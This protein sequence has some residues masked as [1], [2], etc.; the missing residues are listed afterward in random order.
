MSNAGW[1]TPSASGFVHGAVIYNHWLWI[2]WLLWLNIMCY[3]IVKKKNRINDILECFEMTC[4]LNEIWKWTDWS[5]LTS[6][7]RTATIMTITWTRCIVY[8]CP[9]IMLIGFFCKHKLFVYSVFHR[10]TCALSVW[11]SFLFLFSSALS[12]FSYFYEGYD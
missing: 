6:E 8:V 11:N 10:I 2:I 3:M 7:V 5:G 12:L 4:G 1:K 9:K